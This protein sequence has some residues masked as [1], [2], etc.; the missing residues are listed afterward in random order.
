MTV[1]NTLRSGS[2]YHREFFRD[3]ESV[4]VTYGR[5]ATTFSVA[6]TKSRTQAGPDQRAGLRLN[7]IEPQDWIISRADL[8]AGF[9]ND[10]DWVPLQGD[11]I[12]EADGTL[13]RTYEVTQPVGRNNVWD[14]HDVYRGGFRIHT[15]L[16]GT[17]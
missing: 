15:A 13:T 3:R 5:G 1:T 12:A 7:L 14:W 8:V 10:A 2:E 4:T 9:A 6:A 17:T 11:T 16:V